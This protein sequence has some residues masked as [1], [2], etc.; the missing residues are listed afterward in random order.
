[1]GGAPPGEV[2]R[3]CRRHDGPLA[4]I[5][6]ETLRTQ[7][8]DYH[9]AVERMHAIGRIQAAYLDR[10]LTVLEIVAAVSPLFGLLGTVLGMV[11]VFD[12]ISAAGLGDPNVLS[13][14]I[15]QALVTTVAGLC[16]AIPALAFHSLYAKRV[17]DL[18][19]EMQDRA[20]E[21]IVRLHAR[22]NAQ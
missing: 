13:A 4:R 22:K 6:L 16:I 3:V 5:I 14:G 2:T 20:T 19:S 15:S 21:F 10:G 1:V 18:A 9:Q 8:L 7:D 17:E 12:A 11:R